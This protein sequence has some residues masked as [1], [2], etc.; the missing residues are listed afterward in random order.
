[1]DVWQHTTTGNRSANQRIQLL[2][3]TDG[4]LQVT[5]RDTLD[6]QVL[7][8]VACQLK[9]FCRKVFEDGTQVH[10]G[11]G[12]HTNVVLRLVLEVTVNTSNRELA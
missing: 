12:A 7:R 3:T 2:V 11:L 8:G 10:G 9:H 5:G 1:M 4:E 6:A